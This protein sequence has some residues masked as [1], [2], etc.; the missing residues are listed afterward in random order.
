M[1]SDAAPEVSQPEK[2]AEPRRARRRGKQ[3]PEA[4]GKAEPAK[5]DAAE[6]AQ[7]KRR[8]QRKAAAAHLGAFTHS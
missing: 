7:P 8:G 1:Q 6:A 2:A 5:A 3:L 4:G